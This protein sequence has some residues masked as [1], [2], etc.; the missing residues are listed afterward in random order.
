MREKLRIP[1]PVIVEGKFDKMKLSHV[2]DA[3]IITTDGFG[4]FNKKEKIALIKRLSGDGIIVLCDSD[5][6]GGVIRRCISDSIEKEKIYNLYIPQIE[7][8]E[9]RKKAPS[10]E[11]TLGVEGMDEAL[12]YELFSSF[13]D[14]NLWDDKRAFSDREKVTKAD[15][16]GLSL[17]G[18]DGCAERRDAICDRLS[19]PRDMTPKAFLGAVNI[20]SDREDF[21]ALVRE[22]FPSDEE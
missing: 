16:Y 7:G 2:I 19:L 8:K 11:G 3:E 9:R 21:F 17:S 18:S 14:K 1:I 4:I 13:A 10:K 22:I 6:A 20:V 12:L 15:L 5:G